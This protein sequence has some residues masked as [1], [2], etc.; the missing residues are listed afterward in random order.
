MQQLR[1]IK[2]MIWDLDGALV[3]TMPDIVNAFR[4]TARAVGY[5]ELTQEQTKNKVGGGAVKAFQMLF[6]DEGEQYV[7]PAVEYFTE[8]YPQHCADESDL[9]PGAR[10]V[11]THFSGKVRYA[12]ATAKIRSATL[13]VLGAVG[14]KDT[15]DYIVAADDMQRMKPD[16]QSIEMILEHFGVAPHEAV[17]IGDMATDVQAGKAA[18]VHTVAVAYGY[19]KRDALEAAD[20]DFLIQEPRELMDII[21]WE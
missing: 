17:M 19:G 2:V 7:T 8:Y 15:F 21:T 18:G 11:L 10:D 5:G 6:G 4:A 12:M 20:A 14:V 1:N 9:Y 16:P 13:A 3:D